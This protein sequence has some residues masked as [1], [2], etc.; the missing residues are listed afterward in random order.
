MA[1]HIRSGVKYWSRSLP[2]AAPKE[3]RPPSPVYV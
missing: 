1:R 3:T 2:D